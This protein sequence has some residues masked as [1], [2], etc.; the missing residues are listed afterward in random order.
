MEFLE[1]LLQKFEKRIFYQM[2]DYSQFTID[3]I[4]NNIN[5][6]EYSE[7]N[8][9]TLIGSLIYQINNILDIIVDGK[10]K[11]LFIDLKNNLDGYNRD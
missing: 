10:D 1:N 7:S 4:E 8:E 3:F 6:L 2:K 5:D 9:S 11:D